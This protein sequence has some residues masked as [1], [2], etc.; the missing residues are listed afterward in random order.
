[1][2]SNENIEYKEFDKK[3]FEDENSE[4]EKDFHV[5]FH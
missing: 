2:I 4:E 3:H 5:K 1:M